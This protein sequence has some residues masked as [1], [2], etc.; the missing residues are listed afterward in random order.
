MNAAAAP[1]SSTALAERLHLYQSICRLD[2]TFSQVK[3]FKQMAMKLESRGSLHVERPSGFEWKVTEPSPLSVSLRGGILKI[4]SG[5]GKSAETQVF[6][7]ETFGEA[8]ASRELRSLTS[9]MAWLSMDA[10]KLAAVY[11]VEATGDDFT[12]IPK[13]AS[14]SPFVQLN[15]RLAKSGALE[16]LEIEERSGDSVSL[17]FA[18]PKVVKGGAACAR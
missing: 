3:R 10:A 14:A 18:P 4:T 7:L 17:T 5:V 13:D 2:T 16:R 15:L 9:L 11:R 8:N 12:F 1:L 6:K